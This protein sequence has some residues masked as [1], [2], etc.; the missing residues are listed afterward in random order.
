MRTRTYLVSCTLCFVGGLAAAILAEHFFGF[1]TPKA[2]GR[3]TSLISSNELKSVTH[4]SKPWGDLESLEIPLAESDN[5][6]PDRDL[7]LQPPH[8]FFQGLS[9]PEL[10]RLFDSASLTPDEESQ[11]LNGTNCQTFSNGC[12]LSPPAAMV[13]SLS[14]TSRRII[15]ETLAKSTNN[16]PQCF[17]FRFTTDGFSARFEQSSLALDKIERLRELTYTNDGT[18]CFADIELLPEMLSQSEFNQAI[19]A[20]YRYPAY[21]LRIRIYPDSD[22]NTLVKYWGKRGM[23]RRVRPILES[24]AKVKRDNGTSVN[25]SAFFPPFARSRLFTFPDS[26]REPQSVREDCIWSSMNFF[27]EQ[28]DMSF[29]DS[30]HSKEVLLKDFAVI[31]DQPTYGD[32]VCLINDKGDLIHMCVYIVDDFVFTKNGINQLQP[33]V[34]MKMQDMLLFFPS[35]KPHRFAILRRKE[36]ESTS[37]H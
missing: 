37:L 16:Y 28:P 13:R 3:T 12:F 35:E 29:L 14:S 25:V 31:H 17:P 26:W 30:N 19:E 21:R 2:L 6:F 8:W 27:N 32:L 4:N 34:L 33:W 7:R 22:I 11:L 18:I 1:F 20:F 23:E 5:L 15:Y 10:E 36:L 9:R 24:F